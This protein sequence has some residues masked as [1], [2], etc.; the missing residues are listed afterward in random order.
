MDDVD[1][2]IAV[3]QYCSVD[4][5][6]DILRSQAVQNFF[7]FH[8]N[9]R[10]FNRNSDELFVFI[11]QLKR[12]PDI[13]VLTET[14]FSGNYVEDIYG[15]RAH[16]IFRD[17]KRGGGVSI[18]IKECYKGTLIP[19]Y[20]YVGE[21]FEICSCVVSIGMRRLV[22]HGIYR[23]P[24]RDIRNFTDELSILLSNAR[25]SEDVFLV[26]DLNI[27]LANP[28][29]SES[30]FIY[31][32]QASSFAPLIYVPTHITPGRSSCLDH[33]WYNQLYDVNSGVFEVDISDH[34]P[35][36]VII[37]ICSQSSQFFSKRFRDHS[38]Q[39]LERL[40]GELIEFCSEFANVLETNNCSISELVEIFSNRI[41]E[42]YDVCCPVRIKSISYNRYMK[43]WLSDALMNCIK[44]KHSLYI[45]YKR[46]IVGLHTYNTFKNHVTHILRLTKRRYFINKFNDGVG[47][48][49][50]TWKIINSLI[51]RPR[52][53]N[54]P[55]ELSFNQTTFTD[56]R[57]IAD[58]FNRYFSS[59]A[60]ELDANMPNTDTSPIDYLGDRLASSFFVR[61]VTAVDTVTE[62]YALKNK[63]CN[64]RSI[65]NFIYRTCR[66]IFSPIIA[67]LFNRSVSSGMFPAC[68][69]TARVIPIYK[70]GDSTKPSNYRPISTLSVLSRIFEKLMSKQLVSF[71]KL[72]NVF[73][74]CQFGFRANSSTSDAIL[75]FLNKLY[76]SLDARKLSIAVFLD[77]SKAF[78]TVSHRIL[79]RKLE[80]LGVRGIA[81]EWFRSYLRDRKQYVEVDGIKSPLCNMNYGVP[82]G[83]VLGPTLFLIYINDMS[84]CSEVLNFIHFAD[85]T[86]VSLSGECINSLTTLMNRELEKIVMWLHANRLS[87][88]VNK[89]SYMLFTD[90]A[91]LHRPPVIVACDSIEYVDEVNFLG[92][93]IDTNLNFKC[94]VNNISKKISKSI[95]MINRIGSF[96]PPEA[97]MKI[98]FSLIYSRVSYGIVAWGRSSLCNASRLEKLLRRAR[99]TVM[100]P[101]Y[102]IDLLTNTFLTFDSI[103][104]YF[105]CIK[106]F[107]VIKLGQHSYFHNILNS[108][109][110]IHYH[111]T[112]FSNCS[113]FNKPAYSKSKC[114]KNFIY[115]SVCI[116][117]N[118]PEF[119][120]G[121]STIDVFRKRLKSELYLKQI[122]T[123][124]DPIR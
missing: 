79:I 73:S 12:K 57:G 34:Y 123:Y 50:K 104:E 124:V 33:F 30:E 41:Y 116:W 82:Q 114:Q 6:H 84:R 88:N 39:S 53:N 45:Q 9:I 77:F 95:G 87:L 98:Y 101:N 117:N 97:K 4:S 25:C 109:V 22:I 78:D 112:R 8:V 23:P 64:L 59:I 7:I 58:C 43:P 91:R 83:S 42:I 92:L 29:D 70:S 75:Q 14:W 115:Q 32:C 62:M 122:I 72:H 13:L 28:N 35:I 63:S 80:H 47:N 60:A 121:S 105:C 61:P 66:D 17:L 10:S 89:T 16:H 71:F 113:K 69:K 54:V 96:V 11:N 108:L 26:G 56:S 36:F 1:G 3:D 107:K 55:S 94:H 120:K 74:P 99:R 106:L 27:D 90:I 118:L 15:Y 37:P 40:R 76:E 2:E 52:S 48:A 111:S 67:S 18:Y 44:R 93:T 86:T 46:G 119:V 24:D 110:P 31:M 65:P 100:Y 21:N 81:L 68:L 85:D 20:S 102:D 38:V 5:F 49:G 103:Y 19:E 51:N